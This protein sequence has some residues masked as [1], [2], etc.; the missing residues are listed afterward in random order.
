MGDIVLMLV[1]QL[2]SFI[3]NLLVYLAGMILA[4]VYR[5]RCFRASLLSLLGL[6]LLS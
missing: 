4:V 1:S 2:Y 5:Q 3:P 6:G